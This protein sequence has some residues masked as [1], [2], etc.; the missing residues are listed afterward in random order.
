M[1]E[2]IPINKLSLS[3]TNVLNASVIIYG[4]CATIP[5]IIIKDNPFPTP[6][7]VIWSPI[8]NKNA[9]PAVNITAT[10]I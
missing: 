3:K 9:V 4:S 5:A 8:H 10:F 1:N 6:F 7:C 2:T